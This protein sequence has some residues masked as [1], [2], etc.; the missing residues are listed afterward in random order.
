MSRQFAVIGLDYFG[1]TV[2]LD[3]LQQKNQVMGIDSD[4]TRVNAVANR[5]TDTV[6]ADPRDERALAEL[7]L[8]RFDAVLVDLDTIEA[9]VLC[10]MHLRDLDVRELWVRALSDNHYK[11]LERLAVD[12]IIYPERDHGMHVAQSLNYRNVVDMIP[13]GDGQYVVEIE[14][15]DALLDR[16]G[17]SDGT[18]RLDDDESARLVAIKRGE[19]LDY[20]PDGDTR[21]AAGDHVILIGH[22]DALSRFGSRR[23]GK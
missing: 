6:I 20:H 22:L 19:K 23:S 9:S 12:R 4:E 8:S 1:K 3:L 10:A 14:I 18:I 21:M 5:L 13:L 7:D 15:T 2:A 16:N 17:E 11:L